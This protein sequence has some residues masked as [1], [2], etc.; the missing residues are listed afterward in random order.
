MKNTKMMEMAKKN[1][2]KTVAA[3]ILATAVLGTSTT[4]FAEGNDAENAQAVENATNENA[5]AENTQGSRNEQN[6]ANAVVADNNQ[7]VNG[8]NNEVNDV[9]AQ[10]EQKADEND[11][12]KNDAI[13]EDNQK[14]DAQKADENNG[15]KADD[16]KKADEGQGQA[17]EEK[18]KEEAKEEEKKEEKKDEAKAE[19]KKDEAKAEEKKEEVK[20]EEKKEEKK[21][22]AKAEEK[23]DQKKGESKPALS[24]EEEAKKKK[25][26]EEFQKHISEAGGDLYKGLSKILQKKYTSNV[27]L[28]DDV[29]KLTL[30]VAN[31]AY[32]KYVPFAGGF[33]DGFVNELTGGSQEDPMVKKLGEL[34]ESI[35]ET[36]KAVQKSGEAIVNALETSDDRNAMAKFN[37]NVEALSDSYREDSG[38]FKEIMN[39][40][41]DKYDLVKADAVEY[42]LHRIYNVNDRKD[43][44]HNGA[45][46]YNNFLSFLR[47]V[48]GRGTTGSEKT[49]LELTDNY[50]KGKGVD[51]TKAQKQRLSFLDK[52]AEITDYGYQVLG[53]TMDLEKENLENKKYILSKRMDEIKEQME[54]AAPEEKVNLNNTLSAFYKEYSN[55]RSGLARLTDEGGDFQTIVRNV[56]SVRKL[57]ETQYQSIRDAK[58]AT[59]DRLE[60]SAPKKE[61]YVN[62]NTIGTYVDSKTGETWY[63]SIGKDKVQIEWRDIYGNLMATQ[64]LTVNT[65][66]ANI[67]KK[68]DIKKGSIYYVR[69]IK[70]M[71]KLSDTFSTQK[72]K[73][74]IVDVYDQE[75]SIVATCF[76]RSSGVTKRVIVGKYLE[77]DRKGNTF[78]QV[79]NDNDNNNR[80]LSS[81]INS[82]FNPTEAVLEAAQ[83][84]KMNIGNMVKNNTCN[85]SDGKIIVSENDLILGENDSQKLAERRLEAEKKDLLNQE[86]EVK[87]QWFKGL[88]SQKKDAAELA[89][90]KLEKEKKQKVLASYNAL[91]NSIFSKLFG[92][93]QLKII[94]GCDSEKLKAEINAL[95]AKIKAAETKAESATKQKTA[96]ASTG[97]ALQVL[98][99]GTVPY[100]AVA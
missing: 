34:N 81:Y 21:D 84:F 59:I 46:F 72:A 9:P 22:E 18:A 25:E 15:G 14:A 83:V 4:V 31:K 97:N 66:Y 17:V 79:V 10:N 89:S 86:A 64:D 51:I 28:T 69:D 95:D 54:N 73:C 32:L 44:A 100:T 52:V 5:S 3:V 48:L 60:K 67:V 26:Q 49:I 91:G 57:L 33:L 93:A 58:A 70:D 92:G 75:P 78:K 77:G 50:Y 53:T 56:E 61:V 98:N 82:Y 87:S 35:Q 30:R 36:T 71:Q 37:K 24:K 42:H 11:G 94:T 80:S 8:G 41:N 38:S 43:I 76:G 55:C 7:N 45:T 63:P 90:M 88:I 47:G 39:Y 1:G 6:N 2:K 62:G 27:E 20:A 40:A 85:V 29:M 12:G 74:E 68:G 23:K 19:E 99:A 96:S 13:K 65:D 16:E